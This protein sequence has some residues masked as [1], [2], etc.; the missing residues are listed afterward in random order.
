MVMKGLPLTCFEKP[1]F[2]E[3]GLEFFV[4]NGGGGLAGVRRKAD[5]ARI[6]LVRDL[7]I[8]QNLNMQSARSACGTGKFAVQADSSG[9]ASFLCQDKDMGIKARFS[10]S[11]K[12]DWQKYAKYLNK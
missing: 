1:A 10:A 6:V 7:E 12:A 8:A 9:V 2:E 4:C 5:P 11:P 3:D